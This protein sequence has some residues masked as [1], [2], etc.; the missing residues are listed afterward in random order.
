[1]LQS[2]A[3]V[4]LG[5]IGLALVAAACGSGSDKSASTSSTTE[6]APNSSVSGNLSFVGIWTGPE[7]KNFQLVLD[8]FKKKFPGVSREVHLG[9]RQHADDPVD[10][11][12]GRQSAGSR[13]GW[14]TGPR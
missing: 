12:R 1:M 8:G 14:P 4:V 5:A 11:D 3:Y 10:R 9:R 2:R 6:S 7:Q 13:G